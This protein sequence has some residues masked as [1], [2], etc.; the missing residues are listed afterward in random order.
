MLLSIS[1]D[2]L[3]AMPENVQTALIEAGLVA[4]ETYCAY[5][6]E[7]EAAAATAFKDNGVEV[8]TFT[9]EDVAELDKML[10]P[11]ADAWAKDMDERGKPGTE[12]LTTFRSLA[13]SE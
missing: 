7:N 11:I 2:K 5:V 10:T 1:E 9:D 12:T 13:G 8:Y 4:D 3:N 6:D